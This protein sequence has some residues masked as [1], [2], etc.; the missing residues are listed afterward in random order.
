MNREIIDE[1]DVYVDVHKAIR[2]MQP[3]PLRVPKGEFVEQPPSEAG[4]EVGLD[5]IS[6]VNKRHSTASLRP[7]LTADGTPGSRKTSSAE[8]GKAG[9]GV[10]LTR[11]ASGGT[12]DPTSIR[13]ADSE[14]R[15]HLKHLGPSN[16]ASRPKATR[17]N[18]VKIKPG[19]GGSDSLN[20]I[21][22]NRQLKLPV[23]R[24]IS[25][26]RPDRPQSLM[27][28]DEDSET[29]SLLPKRPMSSSGG[30]ST[31]L[32]SAGKDASDGVHAVNYGTVA[33]SPTSKSHEL[34]ARLR[35]IS[36][37]GYSI[38]QRLSEAEPP[39]EQTSPKSQPRDSPKAPKPAEKHSGELLI[40][41]EGP[42]LDQPKEEVGQVSI[43]IPGHDGAQ[44]P[45]QVGTPPKESAPSATN[46]QSQQNGSSPGVPPK[47]VIKLERTQSQIT[48]V[49]D[50]VSDVGSL[51]SSQESNEADNNGGL[52]PAERQ[53]RSGSIMEH[54]VNVGGYKKVVLDITSSSEDQEDDDKQ[55]GPVGEPEKPEQAPKKKMRGTRGGAK[56]KEKAEKKRRAAEKKEAESS[57][58]NGSLNG[59]VSLSNREDGPS[60]NGSNAAPSIT[61]TDEGKTVKIVA[62]E[63]VGL[64]DSTEDLAD[65]DDLPDDVDG[66]KKKK[67]R[68]G[69][70]KVTARRQK[71][72][73]AAAGAVSPA[74]EGSAP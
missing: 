58:K 52:K 24:S 51:L 45:I 13:F 47:L 66:S 10:T 2:R 23:H 17:I 71:S 59:G 29:T 63:A 55:G 72:R 42:A 34:P 25:N 9:H 48:E 3:A 64:A 46:G 65:G 27:E 16:L 4:R 74:A 8:A 54:E 70:K 36:D 60:A 7:T 33:T 28:H 14:L 44:I 22:E 11:R 43:E 35:G 15:E 20:N 21:P 62:P 41:L 40:S 61:K 38:E 37:P 53:T 69:G 68:R 57:A 1:S 50:N 18:T 39:S 73:D 31:G 67:T 56:V 5:N 30:E 32:L 6:D 12:G 19:L 49:P 26:L